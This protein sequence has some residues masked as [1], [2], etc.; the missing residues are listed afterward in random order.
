MNLEG[1]VIKTQDIFFISDLH[2][3]HKHVIE[4]DKR[5]YKD[6]DEMHRSIV[7]N[8]NKKVCKDSIVYILGDLSFSSS[9]CKI[10]EFLDSLNG[11]KHLI[12]GNHDHCINENREY[13]IRNNHLLSIDYYNSILIEDIDAH[14]GKQQIILSHYPMIDWHSCGRGS[15]QLHGHSHGNLIQTN[16]EIYNYKTHDV[17]LPVN[18]YEPLSYSEIKEIMKDKKIFWHH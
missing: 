11:Q 5:P 13:F 17:G 14:N 2:H 8:W 1:N 16:N 12:L 7:K 15:W 6:L 9:K 10:G 3:K 18:N 4:F